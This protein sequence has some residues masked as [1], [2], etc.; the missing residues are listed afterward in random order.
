MDLTP[1]E[2]RMF[3]LLS[4]GMDHTKE[5]LHVCLSDDLARLVAV[6]QHLTNLRRKLPDGVDIVCIASSSL[7]PARYRMV[8]GLKPVL[9]EGDV[10]W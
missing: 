9:K 2:R 3:E 5:E 1:V 4:D 7:G 8:R 6:R 10:P